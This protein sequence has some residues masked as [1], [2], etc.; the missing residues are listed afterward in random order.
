[1]SAR[2]ATAALVAGAA[3][4][5]VGVGFMVGW[6]PAALNN[7]APLPLATVVAPTAAAVPVTPQPSSIQPR[8]AAAASA[9]AAS[10]TPTPIGGMAF[11]ESPMAFPSTTP[12]PSPRPTP[13]PMP[14]QRFSATDCEWGVETMEYDYKLD[15]AAVTTYPADAAFYSSLLPHWEIAVDT[16]EMVC[17]WTQVYPDWVNWSAPTA[18]NPGLYIDGT[19]CT[20]QVAWFQAAY[21]THIADAEAN[22]GDHSWDALWESNYTRLM[23]MWLAACE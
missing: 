6:R 4:F 20:D 10:P 13:P 11:P 2:R 18:T 7:T 21:E 5:A 8:A 3:V 22:P 15:S 16:I 17:E 19:D 23:S 9:A 14:A 1:M 12:A